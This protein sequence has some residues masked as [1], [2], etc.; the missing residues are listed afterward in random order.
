MAW[1]CGEMS[2]RKRERMLPM[3]RTTSCFMRAIHV[4]TSPAK[5]HSRSQRR[6]FVLQRRGAVA[7]GAY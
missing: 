5:A 1:R 7:R 4:V 2:I 3:R 6:A